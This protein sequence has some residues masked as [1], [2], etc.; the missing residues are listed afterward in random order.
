MNHNIF[1]DELLKNA[2][3]DSGLCSPPIDAQKG[4][5]ILIDHFLG[6]DFNM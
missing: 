2:D 1:M 5:N 4:L 6:E 3:E